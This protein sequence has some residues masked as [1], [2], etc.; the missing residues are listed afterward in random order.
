MKQ[1]SAFDSTQWHHQTSKEEHASGNREAFTHDDRWKAN[2]WTT[3]WWETSRWM[4]NDAVWGSFKGVCTQ[5]VS[6]AHFLCTFSLRDAQTRTR[7]AQGVCSAHVISLHLTFS[8]LMFHPPSLLFPHGHFDNSFPSA[9]SLPNCSRSESAG[10]AHLR[11]SGEEFGY[12]ADPTHSQILKSMLVL[13]L[14]SR[15][16]EKCAQ[17]MLQLLGRGGCPGWKSGHYFY[18][19][20]ASDSHLSAV[21][22]FLQKIFWG[23]LD[24]QQLLV[25]EGSGVLG[26]P[27]V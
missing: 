4:W 26:S 9:P 25:V 3:S 12:L 19:P 27:E 23:A 16:L 24:G 21:R 11:T 18:E 6:H 20:L 2:W 1:I 10:Q 8:I 13:S 14:A 7:V 5:S 17:L 22:A 15:G